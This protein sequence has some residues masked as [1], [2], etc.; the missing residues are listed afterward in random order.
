MVYSLWIS[1]NIISRNYQTSKLRIMKDLLKI[2]ADQI[3][4][5]RNRQLKF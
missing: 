4:L 1:V 2:M 3:Q 5:E